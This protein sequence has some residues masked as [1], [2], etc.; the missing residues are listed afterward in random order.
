MSF[1]DAR[2]AVPIRAGAIPGAH[3][4]SRARHPTA[5]S[6]IRPD[7]RT[8]DPWP[9]IVRGIGGHGKRARAR[10]VD[11]ATGSARLPLDGKAFKAPFVF[12]GRGGP[13]RAWEAAAVAS[14]KPWRRPP[15]SPY[16]VAGGLRHCHSPPVEPAGR[17]GQGDWTAAWSRRCR[18][19]P[20]RAGRMTPSPVGPSPAGRPGGRRAG[21][22]C[23]ALAKTPWT[24]APRVAPGVPPPPGRCAWASPPAWPCPAAQPSTGSA[25]AWA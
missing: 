3:P 7:S 20:V 25:R 24:G 9:H 10:H 19:R 12:Q 8:R 11:S 18:T 22:G 13:P 4:A 15:A 17:T 16:G 6:I 1:R 2:R 21:A 5:R 23:A 14:G